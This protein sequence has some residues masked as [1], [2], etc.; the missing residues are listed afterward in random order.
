M[1]L[2]YRG[3]AM[4]DRLSPRRAVPFA[5]LLLAGTTAA[6]AGPQEDA[7]AISQ[8]I[9]GF[10]SL[11][12]DQS[13]A[14]GLR[15]DKITVTPDGS[16][17]AVAV[18]GMRLGS[19]RAGLD[20]GEIDYRL[21][22]QSDGTYKVGDLK[23]AKEMPVIGEDG[24]P[25]GALSFD[26]TAFSGIWS[27]ALQSFLSLD[28]QAKDIAATALDPKATVRVAWASLT[29]EGKDAGNNR[30]DETVV[31]TLTDVSATDPTG[32]PFKAARIGGKMTLH[33]LDFA[34]YRTQ[35]AKLRDLARKYTATGG[36]PAPALTDADRAEITEVAQALP[37]LVS[38]TDFTLS[39]DDTSGDIVS[40]GHVV[41]AEVGI[42][43]SGID[44][45]AASLQLHLGQ[46][47]LTIAD[48]E[49]QTPLG[50]A[51]FPK[52]LDLNLTFDQLPIA[53]TTS[54]LAQAMAA[55]GPMAQDPAALFMMTM[56]SAVEAAPL[57]L[58]I[59]P[60]TIET[61]KGRFAFDGNLASMNGSP[62]GKLNVSATGL[63]EI[64]HAVEGALKDDPGAEGI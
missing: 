11:V 33:A 30:L 34:G 41:H 14:I 31:Y 56:M 53:S 60:S 47:D 13:Q 54:N 36:G 16:G 29:A 7:E 6:Q 12:S 21:E 22:L 39:T 35:M 37:K 15:H 52:S 28:W 40:S 43:L 63:A 51:L 25:A 27:S 57:S 50:Q 19:G 44:G 59:A 17:Y 24:K 5:I 2:C 61:A 3:L 9:E 62:F 8:G 20:L 55:G 48:P 23:L 32:T 42:A 46:D 10:L 4:I 64:V 26:T 45:D 58:K 38:G 49:A 18:T 1:T